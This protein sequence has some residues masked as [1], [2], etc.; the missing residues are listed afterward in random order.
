MV[1]ATSTVASDLFFM[2]NNTNYWQTLENNEKEAEAL[3]LET[4]TNFC[5][6]MS[7]WNVE[8]EPEEV[9]EG[10]LSRV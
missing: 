2:V 1:N 5:G 9:V 7:H 8:L 4:A 3:L 10:Y 6:L